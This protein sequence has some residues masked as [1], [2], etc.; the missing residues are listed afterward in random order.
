[1][2]ISNRQHERNRNIL[3]CNMGGVTSQQV[4]EEAWCTRHNFKN[5]EC[6][7]IRSLYRKQ[8]KIQN[9]GCFTE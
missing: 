3:K 4:V 6:K 1:M 9:D 5:V 8:R 7:Y 2:Q